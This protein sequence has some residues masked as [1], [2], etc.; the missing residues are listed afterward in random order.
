[1]EARLALL[2]DE[3]EIL[4]TLHAYG[5]SIDYGDE[6]RWIDCWLPDAVLSWPSPRY[7]GPF[8]GHDRLRQ[9]FLGHT[10]APDFFHKHF[11]VDP[12]IEIDGDTAHVQSYYARLDTGDDGPYIRGYGRYLDVL[13]RCDDGRWR[14]QERRAES[15]GRSSRPRPGD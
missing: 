6:A 7:D 1:M 3:R 10:H 13:L 14:F 11:V 2:E 4:R 8:A 5:S 9:A 12:Q 15:E